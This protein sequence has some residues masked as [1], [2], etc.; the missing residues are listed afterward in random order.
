MD[1]FIDAV[2]DVMDKFERSGEGVDKVVYGNFN[3]HERLVIFIKNPMFP[4]EYFPYLSKYP[5]SVVLREL[6]ANPLTSRAHVQV[7]QLCDNGERFVQSLLGRE[8]KFKGDEVALRREIVWKWNDR[9]G[10]LDNVPCCHFGFCY[11]IA[12]PSDAVVENPMYNNWD[13]I[14]RLNLIP[15]VVI[16]EMLTVSF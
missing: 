12:I 13:S 14:V 5:V 7:Q 1:D 9:L 2:K 6:H 3:S 8:T 10:D 16:G 15:G 11:S 4:N